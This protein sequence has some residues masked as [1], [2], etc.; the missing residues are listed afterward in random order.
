MR[1]FWMEGLVVALL[2]GASAAVCVVALADAQLP[3]AADLTVRDLV[4][5]QAA[6]FSHRSSGE[7]TQE[8]R[9]VTAPLVTVTIPH[10]LVIMRHQ[11]TAAEYGRCVEAADRLRVGPRRRE[12]VQGR[13]PAGRRTIRA[14]GCWRLVCYWPALRC[15]VMIGAG[16]FTRVMRL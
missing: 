9:I 8:V 7:F 3:G 2:L 6:S 14:G 1:R 11:V 13:R 5:L 10:T 4:E 15:A 12:P 16:A